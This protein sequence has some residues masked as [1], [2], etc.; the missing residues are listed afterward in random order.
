MQ[1]LRLYDETVTKHLNAAAAAKEAAHTSTFAVVLDAV[2]LPFTIMGS[3]LV[4]AGKVMWG[5]VLIL[6]FLL[7]TP[8]IA[9]F[10]AVLILLLVYSVQVEQMTREAAA[11]IGV[12]FGGLVILPASVRFLTSGIHPKHRYVFHFLFCEPWFHQLGHDQPNLV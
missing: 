12:F 8:A 6:A 1:R 2:M 7:P 4:S 11:V 3:V 5:L 9:L 10:W